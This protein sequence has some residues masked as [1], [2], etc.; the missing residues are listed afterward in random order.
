MFIAHPSVFGV[1]AEE[2]GRVIGS[3]FM[4][5]GDP[6]RAIGP[7][8][9]D[10][11]SQG[12]GIGRRLME[13]VLDRAKGAAGARLVGDAFN[14]RF[15]ALYASLG[16]EVKEPLLLV[17]GVPRS[18]PVS[19]YTV[20][21]LASDDILGCAKLCAS[22]HAVERTAELRDAMRMFAPHGVERD[23]SIT[24]YMTAPTFWPTN[25]GV[26]DAEGDM[27]ALIVGTAIASPEPVSFLLPVRQASL[28]RWCPEQGFRVVKPMTLMAMGAYGEPRGAWFPS[29]FY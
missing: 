16:F 6:I 19:G 12:S 21:P 28:F 15:A 17:H 25:H 7:V 14:T 18:G 24:G 29:V 22:V 2:D 20:R 5:E 3:A 13:A 26:A 1:V 8:S 23:G 10:P 11:A 9:I 27:R 4:A